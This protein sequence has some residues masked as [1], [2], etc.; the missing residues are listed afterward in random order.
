MRRNVLVVV[1]AAAFGIGVVAGQSPAQSVFTSDQASAGRATY[2]AN[3]SSCH[4]PDMAGRNEAP[5]LAGGNFMNTWRARSTR[6]LFEYIQSTMPPTGGNLGEA[7][8]LAVTAYILQ[9]NGAPSGAQ[10]LTP[11]TAVAIGTIA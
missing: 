8:Y 9:A 7:Q 11:T 10:P 5:Q 4:L 2:E 1:A 3:C 6:D